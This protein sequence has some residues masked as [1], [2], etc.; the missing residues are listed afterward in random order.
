MAA[1]PGAA[2]GHIATVEREL[3]TTRLLIGVLV[4]HDLTSGSN[5]AERART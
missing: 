4:G 5:V 1:R 3:P 2:R